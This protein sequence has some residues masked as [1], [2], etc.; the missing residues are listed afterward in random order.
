MDVEDL[1][2]KKSSFNEAQRRIFRDD[3]KLRSDLD[4][5]EWEAN[6]RPNRQT[7]TNLRT[8]TAGLENEA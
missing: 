1:G 5:L 3:S 8:F 4:Q 6:G 2:S 7:L